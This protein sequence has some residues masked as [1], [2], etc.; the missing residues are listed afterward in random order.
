M[1]N[2]GV[3]EGFFGPAWPMDKRLSYADF[4]ARYG[5][6]FYIYA[7]KQDPH[8]RKAW[9]E[10][11]DENYLQK[12]Q[13]MKNHFQ[14]FG[15]QFGV[16][17]SPFGLGTT[18]TEE[19]KKHL[20]NKL[21]ILNR[22]GIDLLGLFFDDMPTNDHLAETQIEA[23]SIIQKSFRQRIVFCPSYYTPDPILEKVFG[24]MPEHYLEKIADGVPL[25]VSIAW[26]GPK[27]ISPVIDRDHLIGVTSLLK[28]RPFIWENLFANDGPKNCKF[29]KLKPF[30]GRSAEAF[31][32]TE[33]FGFNMMNQPELS[34]ITYLA[35]MYVLEGEEAERAFEK[36]VREICSQ[37]F[38]E[39]ILKHRMDFLE[40]GLDV[41]TEELKQEHIQKLSTLKDPGALEIKEW[42]QGKYIVGSE[43]LTD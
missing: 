33:A 17:F 43:C 41:L 32:E 10:N 37:E 27:V 13:G 28:R 22:L 7:P 30:A 20:E 21:S 38:S 16:G 25:S 1:R 14:K 9:R 42:L 11:W 40:K 23:L 39:F 15:I 18:L 24:K 6:S 36:A 34:K 19:D 26:T 2:I 3:V 8:L 31:A 12:L 35:S 29:L 5:G 4:M